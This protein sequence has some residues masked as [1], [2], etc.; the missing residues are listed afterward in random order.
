[1][2]SGTQRLSV[3]PR[4]VSNAA[5]TAGRTLSWRNSA[6]MAARLVYST[7]LGGSNQDHGAAIA[8]DSS[9]VAYVTGATSSTD[10]PVLNAAQRYNGGGQ[11]AFVTRLSADGNYLL[12]STYLGGSGGTV[13]YPEIGQAI[14]LDTDW[15]CLCHRGDQFARFSAGGSTATDQEGRAGRVRDQTESERRDNIQHVSG[16]IQRGC[17]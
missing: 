10:F 3:F 15:E 8:V 9:G 12:F 1:M 13:M 17:G 14:A 11:D 7:Y 6:R 2:S 16:R 4:T 5:L